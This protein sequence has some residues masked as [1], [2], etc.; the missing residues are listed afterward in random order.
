MSICLN[1]HILHR[2]KLEISLAIPVLNK[3][4]TQETIQHESGEEV[5]YI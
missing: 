2:L 5:L 3:W 4:K 1:K